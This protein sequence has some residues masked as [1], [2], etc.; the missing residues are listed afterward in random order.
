[1]KKILFLFVFLLIFFQGNAGA[2]GPKE[3]KMMKSAKELTYSAQLDKAA[4]MAGELEKPSSIKIE[5]SWDMTP[6]MLSM[7]WGA[8]GTGY[9]IY[10]KKETKVVF[11]L[12]G[13]GLCV[14]PMMVSSTTVNTVVCLV[15][16]IAPFKLE[17]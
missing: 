11:L 3:D 13:I 15:M 4:E 2:K 5:S 1:M 7:I 6:M 12:C 16:T 8:I 9:F 14:V 10:G 17:V